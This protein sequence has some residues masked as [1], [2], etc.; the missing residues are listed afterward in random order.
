MTTAEIIGAVCAELGI[1]KAELAKRMGMLP[2]S[3]YRK[4][5]RESMTLKELEDCLN[6]LGVR[7][8]TELH[9]PNGNTHSSQANHQL[10]LEKTALLEKELEA[11]RRA[12]EFRDKSLRELRSQ[13]SSVLGY[14][15]LSHRRGARA[16]E[17]LASIAPILSDMEATIACALGEEPNSNS[18]PVEPPEPRLL[19]GKRVL[20]VDD[21]ALNREVL[22]EILTDR[23]LLVEE[24]ED[25]SQALSMVAS[26]EPGSFHFI[27]MDIEM[28]V[29]DGYQATAK[30]RALPNRIRAGIPIIALTANAIAENRE[31]A[32]AVGMDDFLVKP[33]S[34]ARLLQSLAR[35]L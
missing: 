25:G 28:P 20:L 16:E 7:I 15:E 13:L 1:A 4:L 8:S 31:R 30:I 10:L 32:A 23:G 19:A 6:V 3:L 11:S 18:L 22:G 21:N 2:S 34:S 9:Y 26:R 12:T 24:A 17:Y 5:A 14:A 27:L 35:F 33:T 29:M